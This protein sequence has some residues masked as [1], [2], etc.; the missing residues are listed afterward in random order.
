MTKR[1]TTATAVLNESKAVNFESPTRLT[2]SM[3][4][5][6]LKLASIW[7]SAQR[8]GSEAA[9]LLLSHGQRC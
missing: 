3:Q 8:P 4:R 5:Q 2:N 1:P 7:T 9:F 6:P